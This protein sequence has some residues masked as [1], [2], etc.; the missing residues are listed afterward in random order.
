KNI[1]YLKLSSVFA[2]IFRVVKKNDKKMKIFKK[3]P[4]GPL[5]YVKIYFVSQC[6]SP[7]PK[8][9][10]HAHRLDKQENP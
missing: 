3:G 9:I 10:F 5:F 8:S 4:C 1:Y 6:K 2:R 7:M